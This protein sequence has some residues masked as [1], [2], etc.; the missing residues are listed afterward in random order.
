[1]GLDQYAFSFT[2]SDLPPNSVDFPNMENE[3]LFF[4]WRKHYNLQH[5]MS[6]LYYRKGGTDTEF[7]CANV[8]LT[9]EDIDELEQFVRTDDNYINNELATRDRSTGDLDFVE[10]ARNIIKNEGGRV[11]YSSWW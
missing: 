6:Q 8:E 3:L 1:M 9:L 2:S 11:Y 4:D 5:W 10:K 7:N